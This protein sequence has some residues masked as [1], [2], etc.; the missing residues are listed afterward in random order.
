MW[1][2]KWCHLKFLLYFPVRYVSF[3]FSIGCENMNRF[4]CICHLTDVGYM[5]GLFLKFACFSIF[6]RPWY[7]LKTLFIHVAPIL[8]YGCIVWWLQVS[9]CN[10]W[11][12]SLFFMIWLMKRNSSRTILVFFRELTKENPITEGLKVIS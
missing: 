11:V 1:Q 12:I 9:S 2:V 3:V 10:L 5:S 7:W 6:L 4:K 8:L